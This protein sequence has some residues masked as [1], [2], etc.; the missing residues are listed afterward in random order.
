MSIINYTIDFNKY[1]AGKGPQ[2]PQD[3]TKNSFKF[4]EIYAMYDNQ[5][6]KQFDTISTD[7]LLTGLTTTLN[8]KVYFSYLEK[9]GT[10]FVSSLVALFLIN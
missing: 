3:K 8:L 2:P 5:K 9:V 1:K 6:G 7:S 10:L 4:G